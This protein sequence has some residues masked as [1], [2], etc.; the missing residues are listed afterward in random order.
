MTKRK[1]LKGC[2]ADWGNMTQAQAAEK[3][4]LNT[5]TYNGMEQ[6]IDNPAIA[7]EIGKL[8]DVKIKIEVTE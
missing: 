5:P 1:T 3:L 7:A 2:R 8:F 6:L 4:G